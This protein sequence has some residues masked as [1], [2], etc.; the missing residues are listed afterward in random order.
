ME[1]QVWEMKEDKHFVYDKLSQVEYEKMKDYLPAAPKVIMDIGCGLGRV[2]IH[3]NS[4]YRDPKALYILADR[5]GRTSNRGEWCPGE[6]EYY[7][8]FGLM[9]S[10]CEI[11]GLKNIRPFDTEKGDWNSLPPVDLIISQFSF[12]FHVSIDRYMDRIHKVLAPGGTAMFGAAAWHQNYNE[13]SF[14]HLFSSVVYNRHHYQ[15]PLPAEDW[16]ILR[17]KLT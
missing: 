9:Q 15:P 8:D 5:D 2:A 1:E 3:L 7:N 17:G 13:K 12:G 14:S 11:N 4:V 10:F 6:D 16:L